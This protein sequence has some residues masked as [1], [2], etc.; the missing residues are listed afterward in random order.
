MRLSSA[1]GGCQLVSKRAKDGVSCCS[2]TRFRI[3]VMAADRRWGGIVSAIVPV[4]SS[5]QITERKFCAGPCESRAIWRTGRPLDEW[6]LSWQGLASEDE[7]DKRGLQQKTRS[8]VDRAKSREESPCGHPELG[9]FRTG[10]NVRKF[11]WVFRPPL[12]MGFQPHAARARRGELGAIGAGRVNSR[13]QRAV[14][15]V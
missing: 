8:I 15:W 10:D 1:T 6:R 12:G 4:P 5:V 2:S 3:L 13:W 9:H 7:I 14:L 11:E